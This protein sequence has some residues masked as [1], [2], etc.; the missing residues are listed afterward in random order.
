MIIVIA[1]SPIE[2]VHAQQDADDI[3]TV[4]MTG[5]VYEDLNGNGTFDYEQETGMVG[6]FL[7]VR[8]GNGTVIDE[9]VSLTNGSY[10]FDNIEPSPNA[11]IYFTALIP[12]GFN[13]TEPKMSA[14]DK[15]ANPLY[16]YYYFDDPLSAKERGELLEL[17]FGFVTIGQEAADDFGNDTV[18][19]NITTS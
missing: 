2:S 14:E 19:S 17:N 5:T 9:A 18:S 7:A 3:S 10:W 8:D 1:F 11:T 13:A 12:P 6:V 15:L 16:I 4:S